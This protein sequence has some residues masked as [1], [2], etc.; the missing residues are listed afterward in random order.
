MAGMRSTLGAATLLAAIAALGLNASNPATAAE[1]IK[2]TAI[3]GYSLKSMWVREFSKFLIPEINKQLA[4][5][6]NYK[7]NWNQAWG[8]QIVKP[9]GVM[10]GMQKGLGDIGVVTTVFH[11]DKVPLQMVAYSAPFVTTNP[12]LVARTVDAL[13]VKFPVYK[14][15]FAKFGQEYLAS[16]A[17]LDTY[18]MFSKKPIK[19]TADFKGHRIGV[20]GLNARWLEGFGAATV[21]GS[22]VGYYNKLKTGV[23]DTIMLWPES[24]VGRKMYEVAPYMLKGDMGTANSKVVTANTKSWKKLPG[25]VRKVIRASVVAY[26]DHTTKKALDVAAASY[27]AYVAKGGKIHVMSASERAK[28]ARAMPNVAKDWA[29]AQEKKGLPGKAILS[30]YMDAM[31]AAKQ[32]ILRH[33]DKE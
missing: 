23:L 33:W 20:A 10:G 17:V 27:K 5:T 12:T 19:T 14:Q 15:A 29:A 1:T 9:K 13:A 8:G 3:D 2:M 24:V 16:V 6:G 22:L 32:P 25:E 7:I 26:R 21:P 4:A 11:Q 30:T 18:Q 31:R 28:W